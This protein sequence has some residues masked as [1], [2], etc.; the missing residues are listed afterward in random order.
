MCSKLF[1]NAL[2][3]ILLLSAAGCGGGGSDDAPPLS[4]T[5][6]DAEAARLATLYRYTQGLG[7]LMLTGLTEVDLGTTRA[8]TRA[9]SSGGTVTYT[10][11]TPNPAGDPEAMVTFDSCREAIGLIQGTMQVK[12][13]LVR[14]NPDGSGTFNVIWSA[15]VVIDGYSMSFESAS[16]TVIR[17]AT[18]SVQIETFG[19]KDNALRISAPDGRSVQFSDV[20]IELA[21]NPASG[22][23]DFG[24]TDVQ[25]RSPATADLNALLRT[26]NLSAP[27][28]VSASGVVSVGTPQSGSLTYRRSFDETGT[29]LMGSGT[30]SGGLLNLTIDSLPAKYRFP[31]SAGQHVWS[32][33]LANPDFSLPDAAP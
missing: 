28:G 15:D 3:A 32:S 13:L 8:G 30:T 2:V 1:R 17:S 22:A 6:A 20:R 10:D 11:T 9:C 29:D 19:G 25:M 21:H 16:G 26:G 12:N 18:G 33:M 24:G 31:G 27:A 7:S 5:V 4:S 23:V 14:L